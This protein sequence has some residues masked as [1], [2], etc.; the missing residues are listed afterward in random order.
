MKNKIQQLID[1][2]VIHLKDPKPNVT[3]NLLPDHQ[4]NMLDVDE[5]VDLEHS[6]WF[7]DKGNGTP[8]SVQKRVPFEVKVATPK[9]PFTVVRAS[10]TVNPH[11]VPWN[12]ELN[13][14]GKAKVAE[15]DVVQGVTRSGRVYTSENLFQGSSNKGKQPAIEVEED[16]IWKK[17]QAKEYSVAEQLNKTPA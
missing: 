6:I 13:I 16:G 4:V 17:I 10:P 2:K 14:L 7:I 11:A 5:D 1:T 8:V 9:T 3:N 15:A 12:Y